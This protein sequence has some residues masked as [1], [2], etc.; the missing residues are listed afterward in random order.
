[1]NHL[2]RKKPQSLLRPVR[3]EA[4]CTDAELVA[5]ALAGE[6]SAEAEIYARHVGY[7]MGLCV[8]LLGQR[9]E[10]EDAVQDTFVDVLEQLHQL[11]E[12]TR[13]R[14]W[15]GRV[16]VHKVH[17]RFRRRR[18]QRVFGFAP[19]QQEDLSLVPCTNQASPEQVVQLA[20]LRQELAKVSDEARAAWL[21]R[22]V[23]GY[24]LDE[25]AELCGCSLAT[26]KRRIAAADS[27]VRAHI[28]LAEVE[29]V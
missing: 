29:H 27:H 10:A 3:D 11:R 9:G 4:P 15:I 12:P 1:M 8:R 24:K 7:V 22:F 26:A 5:R 21:L 14:H 28:A 20:R 25:V 23:D 16:A 18:L 19:A 17:R 13:L 2:P 6:R